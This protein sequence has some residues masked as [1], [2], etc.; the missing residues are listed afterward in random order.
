MPLTVVITCDV[1]ARYRGFLT[2]IMLETA[3]GV[4][5]APRMSSGVRHWICAVLTGWWQALGRGTLVMVWRDTK[6]T[7]NLR[8]ET[9]GD[10]PKEIVDADRI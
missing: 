4:Y 8:I 5:V 9:L 6:A 10:P 2:S 3:P 7:G 1:E